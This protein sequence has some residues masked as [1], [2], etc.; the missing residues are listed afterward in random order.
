[1]NGFAGTWVGHA[2]GMKV[3][4]AAAT[5]HIARMEAKLAS[6]L[7]RD[8]PRREEQGLSVGK[9]REGRAWM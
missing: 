5:Y 8:W 2:D 1:M 7:A 4:L 6:A 3:F 9:H